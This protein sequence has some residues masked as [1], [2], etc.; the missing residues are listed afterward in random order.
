M[1]DDAILG[2]IIR[3]SD[4]R[5]S[6][7]IVAT[8][9]QS[10]VTRHFRHAPRHGF[11]VS[12]IDG[13]LDNEL[14]GMSLRLLRF[15]WD[16]VPCG[17]LLDSETDLARIAHV[18]PSRWR[19]LRDRLLSGFTACDDGYLYHLGMIELMQRELARRGGASRHRPRTFGEFPENSAE[20]ARSLQEY[21]GDDPARSRQGIPIDQKSP[22]FAEFRQNSAK[23]DAEIVE[24]QAHSPSR[25]MQGREANF[26]LAASPA[27]PLD[28][29][30]SL[31]PI[32]PI[33][34]PPSSPTHP[35][36][37]T[38]MGSAPLRDAPPPKRY[39]F[40]G[41][42]VRLTPADFETWRKLYPH[43]NLVL[44]LERLDAWMTDKPA[45]D[46]ARKR[47]FHIVAGALRKAEYDQAAKCATRDDPVDREMKTLPSD[48]A[49]LAALVEDEI[50]P[51]ALA[52][53]VEREEAKKRIERMRE[54]RQDDTA[55][56]LIARRARLN[57]RPTK[58]PFQFLR[59]CVE[60]LTWPEDVTVPWKNGWPAPGRKLPDETPLMKA[61]R[62]AAERRYEPPRAF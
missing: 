13:C 45:A 26:P 39:A 41:R 21:Q 9:S 7:E 24:N 5:K 49:K 44:E 4:R 48:P 27:L 51:M 23:L 32:P 15:A 6:Q 61:R 38:P 22:S 10:P 59:K 25:S 1:P 14:L 33:T 52:D 17:A 16:A 3:L 2:N 42:V 19:K 58:S 20:V 35:L 54:W 62:E 12:L 50:L 53:G 47:W 55:L 36:H 11:D 57:W 30:P 31:P 46:P 40:A 34:T 60:N 28:G 8:L 18:R 43:L 56:V 37:H 29:S